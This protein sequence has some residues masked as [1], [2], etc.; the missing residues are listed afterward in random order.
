MNIKL[1]LKNVIE[2]INARTAQIIEYRVGISGCKTWDIQNV[3]KKTRKLFLT[4][5]AHNNQL[6][7]NPNLDGRVLVTV[8]ENKS[9]E[10]KSTGHLQTSI[11]K[12]MKA[13]NKE[14]VNK[15]GKR[16]NMKFKGHVKQI[17]KELCMD[18]F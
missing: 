3:N 9:Q 16:A 10:R 17:K 14:Q 12:L 15:Y 1:N 11:E 8:E 18:N 7:F 13:L 6:N 2:A 5:G 4:Y